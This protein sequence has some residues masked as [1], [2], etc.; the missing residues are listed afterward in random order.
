M[1]A[2]VVSTA[3]RV[4]DAVA[5]AGG[6]VSRIGP[7]ALAHVYAA[8]PRHLPGIAYGPIVAGL[9]G[10]PPP[11]EAADLLGVIVETRDHPNLEP[12]VRDV[13]ARGLSVQ[14]FHG[15]S[16]ERFVTEAF[17]SDIAARTVC[18]TRLDC[19]AINRDDYNALML[20]NSF[21]QAL[22]GRGKV[23]VFQTDAILCQASPYRLDDF[24]TFDYIGSDWGRHR[25]EGVVVDGGNGGL[26]LRDWSR[27]VE[28]L[29]RFPPD[30]YWRGGK[31]PTFA[32]IWT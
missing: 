28:C 25:P 3:K 24:L 10:M 4:R 2:E 8:L 17:A 7:E 14:I 13:L 26:S 21:W 9:E 15:T 31:T 30:R 5:R 22:A 29:A 32:C 27:S 20:H 19:D 23:L 12:L 1:G 6:D 18:L 16:N 11:P